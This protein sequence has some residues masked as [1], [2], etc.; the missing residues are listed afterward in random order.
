M[1]SIKI[2]PNQW[3]EIY[4]EFDHKVYQRY[5]SGRITKGRWK[6]INHYC[7]LNTFDNNCGCEHDCCGHLYRQTMT[8]SYTFN[9][10]VITV[11]RHYNY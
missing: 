9:Q 10:V 6:I 5:F 3:E 1:A 11:T 4:T 2:N 8:F 7:R